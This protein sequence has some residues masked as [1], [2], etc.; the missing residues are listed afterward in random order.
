MREMRATVAALGVVIA[1]ALG[2]AVV[3]GCAGGAGAP[4]IHAVP[5]AAA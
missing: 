3:G 5:N 1:V 2:A 4:V